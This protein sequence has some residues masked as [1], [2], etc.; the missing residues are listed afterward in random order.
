MVLLPALRLIL[1]PAAHIGDLLALVEVQQVAH[2]PAQHAALAH[3]PAQAWLVDH[4]LQAQTQVQVLALA[5][6]VEP[7][8]GA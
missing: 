1:Q 6:L 7:L 5:R 3:H 2:P 4:P 8:L